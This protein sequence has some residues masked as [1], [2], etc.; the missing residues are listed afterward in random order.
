MKQ[1]I[2][3]WLKE[4]VLAHY[5]IPFSRVGVDGSLLRWIR[6]DQPINL[7]DAG[8]SEGSF[9]SSIEKYC[10]VKHG[11]LI[12]PLPDRFRELQRR[13]LPPQFDVI[14]CALSAE[15]HRSEMNVLNWD[16]ALLCLR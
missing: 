15:N 12:E 7:V 6:P 3:L 4:K 14:N 8:A 5:L 13:F 11:L 16:L 1:Q 10:G 9:T 2:S